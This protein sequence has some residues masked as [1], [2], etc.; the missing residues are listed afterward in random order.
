VD[1]SGRAVVGRSRRLVVGAR[2][3]AR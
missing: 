3:A 1:A 2:A